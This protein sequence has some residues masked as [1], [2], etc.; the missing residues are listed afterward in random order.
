[1]LT[2]YIAIWSG[3]YGTIAQCMMFVWHFVAFPLFAL[4][5]HTA[6]KGIYSQKK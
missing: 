1:M 5:I 4:L 6:I 3:E 2:N